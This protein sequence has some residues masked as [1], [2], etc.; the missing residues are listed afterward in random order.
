MCLRYIRAIWMSRHKKAKQ[1]SF[2]VS[3]G[4]LKLELIEIKNWKSRKTKP[5]S[6]WFKI[7][8]FYHRSNCKW[9]NKI[10]L[11]DDTYLKALL[12]LGKVIVFWNA[13]LLGSSRKVHTVC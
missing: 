3:P 1:N 12:Y 6:K 8:Q 9:S 10:K 4:S 11:V 7:F 5:T 2:V 13:M